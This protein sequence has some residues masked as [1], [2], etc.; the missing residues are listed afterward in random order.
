MQF[1]L[2]PDLVFFR[3]TNVVNEIV[4]LE[5]EDPLSIIISPGAPYS[6]FMGMLPS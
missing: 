3:L 4:K 5:L 1:N 6:L 2:M